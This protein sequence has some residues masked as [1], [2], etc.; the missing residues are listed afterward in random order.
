M[1]AIKDSDLDFLGKPIKKN[2]IKDSDLDFLSGPPDT[3]QDSDLDFLGQPV[4]VPDGI[5]SRLDALPVDEDALSVTGE[6]ALATDFAIGSISNIGRLLRGAANSMKVD[7]S[8]SHQAE[9]P[10]G[11]MI[12]YGQAG[13]PE[14]AFNPLYPFA[15]NDVISLEDQAKSP[16]EFLKI[17]SAIDAPRRITANIIHTEVVKGNRRVLGF[18]PSG[19]NI[20]W[21]EIRQSAVDGIR[22][23]EY[24]TPLELTE[25]V[26]LGKERADKIEGY[27]SDKP[28]RRRVRSAASFVSS[29]AAEVAFDSVFFGGGGKLALKVPG[30]KGFFKDVPESIL[31]KGFKEALEFRIQKFGM[32]K[33]VLDNLNSNNVFLGRGLKRIEATW[34]DDAEEIA[35]AW[36]KEYGFI[37][38]QGK[39]PTEPTVDEMIEVGQRFGLK[40]KFPKRMKQGVNARWQHNLT[41]GERWIEMAPD[42]KGRLNDMIRTD[43]QWSVSKEGQ[44]FLHELGHDVWNR[45][46]GD[47]Q[48]LW[49]QEINIRRNSLVKKTTPINSR[50][51]RNIP[52]ETRDAVLKEFPT[53][54]GFVKNNPEEVF[55]DT[56]ALF[57][58]KQAGK[59]NNR[60]A[61]DYISI[62]NKHTWGGAHVPIVDVGDVKATIL[63]REYIEAMTA[64]QKKLV[65]QTTTTPGGHLKT[66]EKITGTADAPPFVSAAQLKTIMKNNN[67]G[68]DIKLDD[69]TPLQIKAVAT[70]IATAK[71]APKDMSNWAI[72]G[73]LGG[74]PSWRMFEI[75]GIPDAYDLIDDAMTTNTILAARRSDWLHNTKKEFKKRFKINWKDGDIHDDIASRFAD[76]GPEATLVDALDVKPEIVSF[77]S[78]A[79]EADRTLHWNPLADAEEAAG[80]IGK[81]LDID[82]LP[83]RQEF[84]FHRRNLRH[85]MI[86]RTKTGNPNLGVLPADYRIEKAL[87]QTLP[88]GVSAPE[89]IARSADENI[90]RRDWA[91]VSSLAY[92]ESL[93]KLNFE[94]AAQRMDTI[95]DLLDPSIQKHATEFSSQWIKAVRGM[96]GLWDEDLNAINKRVFG[97]AYS[98]VTG[99]QMSDRSFERFSVEMR[100]LAYGG[101]ISFNTRSLLKQAFQSNL[102]MAT[103]GEKA[104]LEGWGSMYSQG[105]REMLKHYPVTVGG[106][107][108]AMSSF[109]ISTQEGV[110]KLVAA[111]DGAIKFG[112]KGFSAIDM[113][114]N[115]SGA[116]NGAIWKIANSSQGNLN[117]MLDFAAKRTV[118]GKLST[119]NFWDIMS[120]MADEGL[121]D[122]WIA[123]ANRNI[124]VTQFS[125]NP[126]DAPAHLYKYGAVGKNVFQFT[127]WPSHFFGAFVPQMWQQSMKGINVF[128]DRAT[129]AQRWAPALYITKMATIMAVAKKHGYNMDYLSASAPV[130]AGRVGGFLPVPVPI[131]PTTDLALAIG[132]MGLG[133]LESLTGKGGDRFFLGAKELRSASRPY[134]LGGTTLSRIEAVRQ[135]EAPTEFIF[136]PKIIDKKSKTLQGL[137]GLGGGVKG[138]SN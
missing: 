21:Q 12:I 71:N 22:N 114:A 82:G 123:L 107:R 57:N 65:K 110:N 94:P 50:N 98:K 122:D 58:S 100:K 47:S 68:N 48:R 13:S 63:A 128:G 91:T 125:Y 80:L 127:N 26:I 126:W 16:V 75:M 44:V 111:Y 4:D 40:V 62:M 134:I 66:T 7:E 25:I 112:A 41:T 137:T 135:G 84:Y 96:P 67:H 78:Q 56:F 61:A 76:E 103:I 116:G 2:V 72:A 113:Y 133:A 64:K 121:V 10:P 6:R 30:L 118:Q 37:P 83:T 89:F 28:T 79:V 102:T 24:S 97:P 77:I 49:N 29:L 86:N 131:S 106:K 99:K 33:E 23:I 20:T 90:F 74:I 55:A 1:G 36:G 35:E 108:L 92:K 53:L 54:Y 52:I 38:V 19:L 109:D 70:D 46:S 81:G 34:A 60:L 42:L 14:K 39:W 136:L 18:D 43:S 85:D 138:L 93:R 132:N 9:I 15:R 51:I 32:H 117:R 119:Q 17:A 95:L 45:I 130:P 87:T 73:K 124:K 69:L 5:R 8:R 115:V 120:A 11:L 104:T 59:I 101:T 105:G 129:K 27:L 31:S 3:I 88:T